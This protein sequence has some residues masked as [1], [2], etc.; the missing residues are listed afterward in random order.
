MRTDITNSNV[1]IDFE[2]H[3]IHSGNN[4]FYQD[5]ITVGNVGVLDYVLQ[6]GSKSIHYTYTVNSDQAGFTFIT[7]SPVTA[8]SDGTLITPFNNNTT[9]QNKSTVTLRL[10]PSNI[11]TTGATTIRKG[12]AGTATNP[13]QRTGG[14]IDRN[15][16][17]IL[18]PNTKYLLRITNLSTNN[19]DI[20]VG[21]LWYEV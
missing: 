5:Y 9:S 11:V 10:N 12:Y 1:N 2:H 17:V 13:A 16:E 20:Q 21:M 6:T 4:Y 15:A 19:N 7:M 8:D 3:Q 14:S 18:K